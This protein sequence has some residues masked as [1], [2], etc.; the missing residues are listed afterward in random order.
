MKKSSRKFIEALAAQSELLNPA[1]QE[2][3]E[4]WA[5]DESPATTLLATFAE[6]LLDAS[7][8]PTAAETKRAM[9]LVEA[10]MESDDT[11]LVNAAATGF[12]E[13]LTASASR[14]EVLPQFVSALGPKSRTYAEA[15]LAFEG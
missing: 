3:D 6:R 14:Y 9:V 1:L 5:P 12:V 2:A 10:A 4:Y 11:E 15:W 13:G 7:K 8:D